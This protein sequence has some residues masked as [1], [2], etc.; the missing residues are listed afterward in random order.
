MEYGRAK[1]AAESFENVTIVDSRLLSS[2]TG[3]LVMIAGKL[4]RQNMPVEKIVAELEDAIKLI[5]CSFVIRDTNTMAR[6]GQITPMV[7]RI[8]QTIWLRPILRM[9]D[10]KLGVGSMLFGPE[11][12]CYEKYVKKALPLKGNIDDTLVFVTCV[13]MDEESLVWIEEMVKQRVPFKHVI[14][15][16][17]SAGIA[18]NCGPGTFGLL[19]L[20]KGEKD[21]KL[22][23]LLRRR[24]TKAEESDDEDELLLEEEDIL[25]ETPKEAEAPKDKEPKEWYETI[26]GLDVA[27][28]IK[29]SG[30]KD[31]YLSVLKMYFESYDIKSKEI[32]GFYEE[33]DWSNYTIKVHAL[34]SSSRL[35]GALDLGSGAEALEKAGKSSDIEYITAHHEEVMQDYRVIRD[36]LAE[37]FGVPE[38]AD[39]PEIPPDTLA[40]AY[41][42]MGE[43]TDAMDYEC[44][45]MVLES[46]QEYSLPPDDKD[47][48]DRIKEYLAN[49]DWDKIKEIL[50]G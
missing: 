19:Y 45:K 42:A 27:A 18:S 29:N 37:E 35:V 10:G 5:N 8:L 40:E 38:E 20:Q 39:L 43:F 50:K 32:E 28:G 30:S 14:F 23:T 36:A 26:P 1:I 44:V 2:A 7:S 49:M 31:A 22:D 17:A 4:A 24:E 48:F 9:K 15:K 16:K 41:Q 46:V 21:Y 25:E 33:G 12:A 11:K 13:G 47:R 6:R 34:K 3:I